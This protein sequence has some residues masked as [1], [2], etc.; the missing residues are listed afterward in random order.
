MRIRKGA[1]QE[2]PAP[3]PKLRLVP[4]LEGLK[5]P[6]YSAHGGSCPKCGQRAADTRYFSEGQ[7]CLHGDQDGPRV[8]WGQ[9]RLHRTCKECGYAR[10]EEVKGDRDL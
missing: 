9:E 1:P 8:R 2:V 5:L 4:P 7:S 3:A 6:P 10:D